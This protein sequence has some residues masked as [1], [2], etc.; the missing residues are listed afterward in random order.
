MAKLKQSALAVW[1]KAHRKLMGQLPTGFKRMTEE[2]PWT[3][4]TDISNSVHMHGATQSRSR[5]KQTP[6]CRNTLSWIS[7]S[8]WRCQEQPCSSN[9]GPIGLLCLIK[10]QQELAHVESCAA[11]NQL[12]AQVSCCKPH[13]HIMLQW[14]HC[15]PTVIQGRKNIA[16]KKRI[17]SQQQQT[18]MLKGK[19]TNPV[20]IVEMPVY[21]GLTIAK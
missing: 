14:W 5:P 10:Q 7:V 6:Q 4:N 18:S 11:D 1:P 21:L 2:S 3:I 8:L 19:P 16:N 12:L 17:L 13:L 9:I 15:I 20:T